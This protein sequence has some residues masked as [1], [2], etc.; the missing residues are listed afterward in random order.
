MRLPRPGSTVHL[1]TSTE[2]DLAGNDR[3]IAIADYDVDTSRPSTP[4]CD[5]S[6]ADLLEDAAKESKPEVADVGEDW[7]W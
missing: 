1:R 4:G 6:G 3:V 5:T 2:T 7:D